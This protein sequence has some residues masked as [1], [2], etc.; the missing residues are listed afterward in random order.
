MLPHSVVSP[1]GR[2]PYARLPWAHVTN[3]LV[4]DPV[5]KDVLVDEGEYL[6]A[7]VENCVLTSLAEVPIRLDQVLLCPSKFPG[8]VYVVDD[9]CHQ[10][11]DSSSWTVGSGSKS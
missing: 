11:I 3:P 10:V 4:V 7:A 9:R 2:Q 8:Y 1:D 6:G 5:R